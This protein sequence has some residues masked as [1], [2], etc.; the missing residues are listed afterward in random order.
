MDKIIDFK[1][2]SLIKW[3][4]DRRTKEFSTNIEP[5]FRRLDEHQKKIYLELLENFEYINR[6]MSNSYLESIYSK[7]LKDKIENYGTILSVITSQQGKINS[8]DSLLDDFKAVN[9]IGN[10][11]SFPIE[12]LLQETID[13]QDYIV[14]FDDIIGTGQTVIDFLNVNINRI[15]KIKIYIICLVIMEEAY[16]KIDMHKIENNLDIVVEYKIKQKKAFTKGYI[17]NHNNEEKENKISSL[18]VSIWE[19]PHSK[20]ILGRDQTQA[21]VAFYRNTP[22]N[23]LSSIWYNRKNWPSIFKRSDPQK[24]NRVKTSKN[25]GYNTKKYENKN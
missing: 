17:F 5:F 2:K 11:T 18:E 10:G 24:L 13:A 6:D 23:T 21:L 20:Y 22:N 3:G 15:R 1:N 4:S 14:F 7:I 12:R 8:S 9:D 16:I 19:N 25:I